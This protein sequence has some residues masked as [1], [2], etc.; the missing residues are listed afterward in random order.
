MVK[1]AYSQLRRAR[2]ALFL[3]HLGGHGQLLPVLH[4]SSALMT[5]CS[6]SDSCV[7]C[8]MQCSKATYMISSASL[9]PASVFLTPRMTSAPCSEV[10]EG[11][12]QHTTNTNMQ[13]TY[14]IAC[15]CVCVCV[16]Q[17]CTARMSSLSSMHFTHTRCP[18]AGVASKPAAALLKPL[19]RSLLVV[20]RT[21]QVLCSHT[22]NARGG[23]RDKG[24]FALE[25]CHI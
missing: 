3:R 10:G 13:S 11:Q 22:T 20:E 24:H 18:A 14:A 8:S 17:H 23:A 1:V 16:G 4:P 15:V 9:A 25:V 19:A 12:Q 7:R 5:L 6:P 2:P 21:C